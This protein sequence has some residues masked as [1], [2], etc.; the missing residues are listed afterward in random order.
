MASVL[1]LKTNSGI[2]YSIQLSPGENEKRPMI[3]LGKVTKKQA[4]A[5]VTNIENLIASRNTNRVIPPAVADWINNITDGLRKRLEKLGIIESKTNGQS[6]AAAEWTEKY[7]KSRPDVKDIT[8]GK[9]QNTA[10]KLFAFF[11]EQPIDSIT[12]QQA[13][14]F[15]VYLKSTMGLSENTVRRIIGLSRQ[16]FKSAIEAGHIDK[17]P[18]MG[19]SVAVRANPARFFYITQEM[20]IKVLEACPDTQW[21]L[22]FGLARWGGLRC[23]SEILR[24]KWQDIDFENNQFTVHA[25]KAEHH[26]DGGIRAVPMFPELRPLF[27]DAF[28][29]A[30]VGDVFCINRFRNNSTNLRT[31]MC[32]IITR[33]GLEPW[34]KLFQNLRSTRETELFK[35]TNGNVKA[36]CSWIGNSPEIAMQH[37]AQV[38]E[39][40]I[41]EAAK[42]TLLND[43]KKSMHNPMQTTAATPRNE[44]HEYDTESD[45]SLYDCGTKLEYAGDREV[46]QKGL[47]YPQGDSNSCYRVENPAS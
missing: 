11:K 39:A 44:P 18:F 22:I 32:R 4:D 7:I 21:R 30:K 43:A 25:S 17:N 23:P 37:Y 3:T 45:I 26:A 10:N 47:E 33:A 36:V 15:R 16:F 8:R 28:D 38:T 19:Q 42:M 14:N 29:M 12:V 13:K 46:V 40:D 6:F 31:Q 41:Q 5:A 1:K 20:A 2:R 27:Q 9:W 35:M 34:P 24:L